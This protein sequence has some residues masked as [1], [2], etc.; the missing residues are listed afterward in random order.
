MGKMQ[1]IMIDYKIF[2]VKFLVNTLVHI[3]KCNLNFCDPTF[4]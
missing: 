4:L 3:R 2:I 1:L